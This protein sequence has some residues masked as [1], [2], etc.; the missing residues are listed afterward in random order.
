MLTV[1]V[2]SFAPARIYVAG[3]VAAPGEFTAMGPDL[4]VVQAVARAGGVRL[5][6]DTGRVFILRR[7]PADTPVVLAVDYQRAVTGGDPRAD[8]RL[9][10]YDIVYVPKTDTARVW[11]W[12]NQHIQQFVPV[13]WG[14][15][16][17]VNPFVN[18][19]HK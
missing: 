1:E 2:K 4:T 7:G 3:E 14:F 17:N 13:T 12:F 11:A 18:N 16:Y 15:S 6:A 10:P 8:V 5:A 19:T 9:A